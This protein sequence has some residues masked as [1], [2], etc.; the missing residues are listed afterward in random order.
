MVACGGID[1]LPGYR[2]ARETRAR[3]EVPST[4]P[5]AR[6]NRHARLPPIS[7]ASAGLSA[8]VWSLDCFPLA[9]GRTSA[10]RSTADR[11]CRLSW[12][13]KSSRANLYSS[14]SS[15]FR[16]RTSCTARS[17]TSY[18]HVSDRSADSP[19]SNHRDTLAPATQRPREIALEASALFV[20]RTGCFSHHPQSAWCARRTV[21]TA[22]PSPHQAPFLV[23]Q[24]NHL[25]A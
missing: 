16:S 15:S 22:S 6:G 11:S 18:E 1:C 19:T 13:T 21:A 5:A 20:I 23:R 9:C 2:Y 12:A 10:Y 25:R 24:S 17:D 8:R 14:K 4:E 7:Q 3:R